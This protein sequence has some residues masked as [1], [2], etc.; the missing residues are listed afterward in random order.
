MKNSILAF[1]MVLCLYG[2]ALASFQNRPYT[3][4][5]E[6]KVVETVAKE[7]KVEE[8][9]LLPGEAML[10]EAIYDAAD[11]SIELRFDRPI[12]GA[13]ANTWGVIGVSA[14]QGNDQTLWIKTPWVI[15]E[16]TDGKKI[17][18]SIEK[19]QSN[20]LESWNGLDLTIQLDSGIFKS[21]DGG[22]G[23]FSVSFLEDV[24]LFV[25]PAPT[26]LR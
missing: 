4:N 18:I 19:D 8:T 14:D 12:A 7:T 3:M 23:N 9:S 13:L 21:T 22:A 6:T 17:V 5:N 16:G 11:K 24:R 26:G 20:T 25:R 15:A 10:L 1:G 2:M